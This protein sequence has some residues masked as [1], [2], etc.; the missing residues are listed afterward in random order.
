[1]AERPVSLRPVTLAGWELIDRLEWLIFLRWFFAIGM[2]VS[3]F[4]SIPLPRPVFW[5]PGFI[6]VGILVA[7]YNVPL[8]LSQRRI[9]AERRFDIVRART[10]A[11]V[12]V[13][14]DLFALTLLIHWSGGPDSPLFVA[15]LFHLIIAA[16]LLPSGRVWAF[17]A[18]ATAL[19]AGILVAEWLFGSRGHDWQTIL[20]PSL[21]FIWAA[22]TITYIG[23]QVVRSIRARESAILDLKEALSQQAAMLQ[24]R[25]QKLEAAERSK[26]EYMRRVTHEL[27]APLAAQ[28]SLIRVLSRQVG[29][30]LPDADRD[31]LGRVEHRGDQ[32]LSLVQDVLALSRAREVTPTR[33]VR[34]IH[35]RETLT[36]VM[37]EFEVAATNKGL[38]LTWGVTPDDA[39]ATMDHQDLEQVV[40]NLVGNAI[41]YTPRGGKVTAKLELKDSELL[42]TVADTGIGISKE[43]IE[44]IGTEY[45]RAGHARQLE[46]EGT[47]LGV[48]IV[49]SIAAAYGG[50]VEI[51]STPGR[52]TRFTVVLRGL[53]E[54]R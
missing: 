14:L 52:G 22:A 8:Y 10:L 20:V 37:R 29:N 35:L 33:R 16:I 3:G 12:Q 38:S 43:E 41:K 31:L 49:K 18:L 5:P 40:E 36:P 54:D 48:S 13:V 23:T 44:Y 2:V 42:V 9:S 4:L 45:Y 28:Q 11:T 15:Y 46:P 39:V 34:D 30:K 27:K 26:S 24:N 17:A 53:R 21:I 1:M 25:N 47:G 7:I 51:D 32:L 50:H 19:Y 6:G